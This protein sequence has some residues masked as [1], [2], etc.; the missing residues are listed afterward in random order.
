MNKLIIISL[1]VLVSFVVKGGEDGEKESL[2][3]RNSY[4]MEVYRYNEGALK[5]LG[6]NFNLMFNIKD[7]FYLFFG[8]G[9]DASEYE[10]DVFDYE[11]EAQDGGGMRYIIKRSEKF[12]TEISNM[13]YKAS[14]FWYYS[15]SKKNY[16]AFME[17]NYSILV[18]K[19][20]LEKKTFGTYDSIR[21]GDYE[22]FL[23]EDEGRGRGLAIGI[24]K[25]I[26]KD[27]SLVLKIDFLR[28]RF[29]KKGYGG[30]VK[31]NYKYDD[32]YAERY[33]YN[34]P[35]SIIRELSLTLRKLVGD[36]VF[37]LGLSKEIHNTNWDKR[38][39]ILISAGVSF[40]Y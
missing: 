12:K 10:S 7:N 8:V 27:L 3:F 40:L 14:L 39:D 9:S 6:I 1:I 34:Q 26:S 4:G 17:L 13:L 32:D 21:N 5:L 16:L 24:E 30:G 20:Y 2:Y 31:G 15:F 28:S 22:D 18:K 23:D 25:L 38:K 37:Y 11:F 29:I 35:E 19:W 36:N 33:Q